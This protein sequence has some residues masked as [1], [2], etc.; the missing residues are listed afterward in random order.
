MTAP[1][2]PSGFHAK[3]GWYFERIDDAGT[4]RLTAPNSMG[5]GARQVVD[6]DEG[7]WASAVASVSATGETRETW[8]DA[9]ELHHRSG[10][11]PP[12]PA[13]GWNASVQV[14]CPRCGELVAGRVEV[15]DVRWGGASVV[16]NLSR[17]VLI[18]HGC[19]R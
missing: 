12:L 3:D 15:D 11:Q 13:R 17:E 5:A 14:Y 19:A 8:D 10:P 9:R 4:V 2:S 1:N 6:L 16:V 7:T 18:D